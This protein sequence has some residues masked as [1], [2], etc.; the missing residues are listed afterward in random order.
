MSIFDSL[1]READ[2]RKKEELAA[3]SLVERERERIQK[4]RQKAREQRNI[5]RKKI[6]FID[7]IA[8]NVEQKKDRKTLEEYREYQSR[9]IRKARTER[10]NRMLNRNINKIST[11]GII[12]VAVV[13]SVILANGYIQNHKEMEKYN[14]AVEYIL[15]EDYEQAEEILQELSIEDS[16][17]LLAYSKVQEDIDHFSGNPESFQLKME[18]VDNIDNEE[19]RAQITTASKQIDEVKKV[20]SKIDSIDPVK[21]TV[22]S[23]EKVSTVLDQT[24]ELDD[25]YVALVDMDNLESA[26]TTINHL[27]KGDAVGQTI[28]AIN[29]IGDITLESNDSIDKA[30]DLYDELDYDEKKDVANYV[31]LSTSERTLSKL[32]EEQEEK[33]RA[34]AERAKQEAEEKAAEEAEKKA[35]QEAEKKKD[36]LTVYVTNSGECFHIDGCRSLRHSRYAITYAQAKARNLRPCSICK[37]MIYINNYY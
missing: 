16:E 1:K 25:R 18:G 10:R 13:C 30:R 27:E 4:E 37:P 33:E 28:T 35:K 20:Q 22:E 17:Q 23:K 7:D 36:S 8:S 11:S 19:V 32:E 2:N 34:E 5:I 14:T 3:R 9:R 26:E 12:V 24:S 29:E 21:V 6:K 31:V 15:E